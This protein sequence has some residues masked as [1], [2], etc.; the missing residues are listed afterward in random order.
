ML[1]LTVVN[2]YALNCLANGSIPLL[3]FRRSIVRT[4]LQIVSISDPKNAG[5][6]SLQKLAKNRIPEDVRRDPVGYSLE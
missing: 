3:D 6:P 4:Y 1:D 2:A 5:R